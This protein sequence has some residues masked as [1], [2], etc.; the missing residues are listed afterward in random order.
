MKT[1]ILLLTSVLVLSTSIAFSATLTIS[2]QPHGGAEY[3]SLQAAYNTAVNGDIL[4][5]E[6]IDI[7][8][9]MTWG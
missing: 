3:S 6:G 1:K 4:S 7:K 2:S 5:S 9:L 8:Y